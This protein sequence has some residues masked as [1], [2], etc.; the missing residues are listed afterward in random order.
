MSNNE[1]PAAGDWATVNSA[2]QSRLTRLDMSMA[3]LSRASGVSET[4]IRYLRS[5]GKRQRSTLVALSAALGFRHSY[6]E[7][8]LRG[9]ADDGG[10]PPLPRGAE[11]R[12]DAIAA[13]LA[14]IGETIGR[15]ETV[16]GDLVARRGDGTGPQC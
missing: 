13:G 14:G 16:L 6:L 8:V 2:V 15:M 11:E 9:R 7:D 4:T 12:L 3:G 10:N 1:L 5:P